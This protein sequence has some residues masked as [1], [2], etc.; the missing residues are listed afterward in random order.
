MS[1]GAGTRGSTTRSTSA[2]CA[3]PGRPLLARLQRCR[4]QGPDDR[5]V[6]RKT[7]ADRLG[8]PSSPVRLASQASL[9]QH[10]VERFVARGDRDRRHEVRPR[11]LHEPFDLA[12]V[13]ALAGSS[14]PILEQV[15]ADQFRERPRALALAIPANLRHRDLEIVV[16]DR[17][18]NAAKKLECRYVPV[19][20]GLRRLRRIGLHEASVRL[21]QVHAEKM[22]LLAYPTN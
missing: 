9:A 14:E 5:C 13:V 20:E 3:Y 22:N 12:L 17:K 10:R 16:E 19:E 21:R 15:V 2:D 1:R 7:L 6:G 8:A 18:R 11:I 4:R